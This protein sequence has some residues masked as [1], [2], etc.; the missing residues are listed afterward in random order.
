MRRIRLAALPLL[1]AAGG[2]LLVCGGFSSHMVWPW[3]LLIAAATGAFARWGLSERTTDAHW[4]ENGLL[5]GIGTLALAQACA[6]LY[7]L[8]YL[9]GA[10]YVLALPLRLG[11][12]L[13]AALIG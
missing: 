2:V 3:L 4:V 12:P 7:P 13:V 1:T 11:V 6:P 9:L 8:M 10:G 5:A